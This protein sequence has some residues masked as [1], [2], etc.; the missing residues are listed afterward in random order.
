LEYSYKVKHIMKNI[1][2]TT[3]ELELL[4][5]ILQHFC[6]HNDM[7][8]TNFDLDALDNIIHKLQIGDL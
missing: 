7:N 5:T 6:S 1:E 2:F 4:D 3:Q 8:R